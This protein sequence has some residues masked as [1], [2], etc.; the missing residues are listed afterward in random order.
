M[1]S[2]VH[3]G[4]VASPLSTRF[5]L[6]SGDTLL[7]Y[8][9]M[10]Q[11]ERK[12][13]TTSA[14]S[15]VSDHM[16]GPFVTLFWDH[17]LHPATAVPWLSWRRGPFLPPCCFWF[18]LCCCVRVLLCSSGLSLR[19]LCLLSTGLAGMHYHT[20]HYVPISSAFWSKPHILG[21]KYGFSRDLRRARWAQKQG[22]T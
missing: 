16:D 4:E 15:A 2:V 5:F 12:A 8:R 22:G 17:D 10:A 18:V 11:E 1:A 6:R 21:N 9:P 3:L 7:V 14:L 19:S 13:G 20:Q